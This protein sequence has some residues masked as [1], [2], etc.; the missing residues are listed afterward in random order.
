MLNSV[1]DGRDT[2][3]TRFARAQSAQT[4]SGVSAET[5]PETET[6]RVG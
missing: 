2:A 3:A 1:H 6:E 5:E 4:C